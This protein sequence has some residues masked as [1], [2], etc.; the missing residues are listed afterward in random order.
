MADRLSAGL[1]AAGRPA[2]WPVEANLVFIALPKAVETSFAD[3]GA[4]LAERLE[5]VTAAAK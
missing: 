5:A 1:A 2:V 3:A 4:A